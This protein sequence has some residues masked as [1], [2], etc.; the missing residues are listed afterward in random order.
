MDDY[1]HIHRPRPDGAFEACPVEEREGIFIRKWL[2]SKQKLAL[3][4]LFS[5]NGEDG[6]RDR[7]ARWIAAAWRLSQNSAPEARQMV[8]PGALM[9][10]LST[11]DC[12]GVLRSVSITRLLCSRSPS[13][14]TRLLSVSLL[15][16]IGH[17]QH[18]SDRHA[19]SPVICLVNPPSIL[20]LDAV[21]DPGAK[22]PTRHCVAA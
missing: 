16:L 1:S 18:N 21:W 8:A 2:G 14:I 19:K 9:F 11:I 5:Y 7:M 12:R 20:L 15:E 6:N 3:A 13:Q 10:A 22:P 17:T 4:A